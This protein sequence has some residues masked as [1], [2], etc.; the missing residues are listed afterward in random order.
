MARNPDWTDTENAILVA[1][2]LDMLCLEL[3]RKPL[4]KVEHTRKIA[5]LLNSRS[6]RS[7]EEKRMNVS[8]V[9]VKFGLPYIVGYKP[10][11]HYQRVPLETAVA[12]GI[13]N[14]ARF[15]SLIENWASTPAVSDKTVSFEKIVKTRP[16]MK[17]LEPAV[18]N[19]EPIVKKDYLAEEQRNMA[20]GD[21]GEKLVFEYEKWRL[22]QEGLHDLANQ[23]LWA[24]KEVGD[25]LGYDIESR[26]TAG[27]SLFIEVKS[28]SQGKYTPFYFSHNELLF[29][30]QNSENYSLYR[31]YDLR[32]KPEIFISPGFIGSSFAYQPTNYKGWVN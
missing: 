30:E 2:Y 22:K 13:K 11:D 12:E 3:E 28:T 26:S 19:F 31:V 29:S 16:E 4:V 20:L 10:H 24:S 18:V 32:K 17:V 21:A 15:I 6:K 8:A 27:E 23:V 7:I 14:S 5:P 9:M 25:G 1:D